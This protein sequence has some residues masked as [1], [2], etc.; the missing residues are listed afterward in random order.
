MKVSSGRIGD[1]GD[2]RE[3]YDQRENEKDVDSQTPEHNRQRRQDI[4]HSVGDEVAAVIPDVTD[5]LA[6][7]HVITVYLLASAGPLG[8][9]FWIVG[10][11]KLTISFSTAHRGNHT[12]A[13]MSSAGHGGEI[14]DA[15][16]ETLSVQRL[17]D[18]E[19][20]A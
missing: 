11:R 4:G 7:A 14:V 18:T 13:D 2:R 8:C 6:V 3:G 20:I 12:G 19:A 1:H 17:K 15:V 10:E 9:V 5:R 16:D